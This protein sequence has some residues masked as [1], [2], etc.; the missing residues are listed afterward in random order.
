M[1]NSMERSSPLAPVAS[2]V[3]RPTRAYVLGLIVFATAGT[4]SL[5]VASW[6][7][8][9]LGLDL[10]PV[11]APAPGWLLLVVVP[12]AAAIMAYSAWLQS[13]KLLRADRAFPVLHILLPA[14]LVLHLW[15][16]I[17]RYTPWIFGITLALSLS[18]SQVIAWFVLFRFIF[19]KRHTPRWPWENREVIE[20]ELEEIFDTE[21]PHD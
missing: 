3:R 9:A 18:V 19:T 5:T 4:V 17:N 8:I 13:L 15:L 6:G 16:F 20:R 2:L 1:S 12:L 10:E 14:I 21:R 7:L 11:T